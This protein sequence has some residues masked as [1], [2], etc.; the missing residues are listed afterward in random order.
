V[1]HGLTRNYIYN[2]MVDYG[3]RFNEDFA[4]FTGLKEYIFI[5]QFFNVKS[6]CYPY[7]YEKNIRAVNA[8]IRLLSGRAK[9]VKS[10]D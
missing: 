6:A 3:I 7:K 10:E 5:D 2:F 9:L 1:E 4:V 8:F